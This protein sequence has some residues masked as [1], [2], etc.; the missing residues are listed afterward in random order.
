M[1]FGCA[2]VP[3]L[4]ICQRTPSGSSIDS[5]CSITNNRCVPIP[6]AQNIQAAP[7]VSQPPPVV[8]Q[9]ASQ[10]TPVINATLSG[11]V[12]AYSTELN[13]KKYYFFGDQ[14]RSTKNNCPQPCNDFDLST[15]TQKQDTNCYDVTVLL[16]RIFKRA[17]QS[18]QPVDF[19]L[20]IPFLPKNLPYPSREFI[21]Q[22]II[23]TGYIYKLFYMFWP[24]F[25]KQNCDYKT[26]RF[27]YIDVR[28]QYETA[29]LGEVT[30][31]EN[32]ISMISGQNDWK[33]VPATFDM[34]LLLT[35]I[36]ESMNILARMLLNSEN[37][38]EEYIETTNLLIRDL[39]LSGGQTLAGFVEPKN[40]RL[41]RLYLESDNF[42]EDVNNLFGNVLSQIPEQ[43]RVDIKQ[44]LYQPSLLIYNRDAKP[45]M[46]RVRA[47]LWELEKEG[48]GSL[49]KSIYDFALNEYVTNLSNVNSLLETWKS[50]LRIYNMIT[51]QS[52]ET[53]RTM[54]DM[55]NYVNNFITQYRYIMEKSYMIITS[56]ALIMDTYTLARMFRKFGVINSSRAIVYAGNAHIETYVK[57][58]E[59]ILGARF[60]KYEPNKR[61]YDLVN[62]DQGDIVSLMNNATRCI[63]IDIN[64][65]N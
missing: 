53:F 48:Q 62:A 51:G 2:Y 24:C 6:G 42:I 39:F 57:F 58:F 16:D 18:N 11:P 21:Q 14:H 15:L 27:H 60:I 29:T 33:T 64:S 28:L 13:G 30:N 55:M 38:R 32:I 41:F 5:R 25:I 54:Q 61:I 20:E 19:Y 17:E 40:V 47:Q 26:T 36:S 37:Q 56:N 12:S 8:S 10:I 23:N 9:L 7:V 34:Y 65:F 3:R 46:H 35:R 59:N 1:N 50:L 52:T 63:P 43:S 49:A 31:E 4:D 45:V 22:E 44:A